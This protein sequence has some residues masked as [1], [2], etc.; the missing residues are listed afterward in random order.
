MQ[1]RS[2]S[3]RLPSLVLTVLVVCIGALLALYWLQRFGVAALG[4]GMAHTP[5]GLSVPI[6]HWAVSSPWRDLIA[7]V[8]LA[9]VLAVVIPWLPRRRWI[10]I[11][12][13]LILTLT[14]L[15]YLLWRGASLNS[16]YPVST[17]LAVLMLLVEVVYLLTFA[18][19]FLPAAWV[20]PQRRRLEADQL[21][22]E[23]ALASGA[24]AALPRVDI[25]ILCNDVPERLVRRAVLTCRNL[26][27]ATS[28]IVLLD[29]A[30][31][32]DL[33]QLALNLGVR[34]GSLADPGFSGAPLI[35][36][37]DAG[38]VP[39]RRFLART[40]GFFD[41]PKVAMVQTGQ[42]YF[43]SEQYNRNLG[44]DLVMSADRDSFFHYLEPARDRFN[45]V[46]GSGSSFVVRLAALSAA[47][48]QGASHLLDNQQSGINLL[49]HGWRVVYL[50]ENLSVGESPATFADYLD[51]RLVS[52]Q[53]HLQVFLQGRAKAMVSKLKPAQLYFF[54]HQFLTLFTP[55]I[56]LIYL[57]LPLLALC[58][59]FSLIQAP[60][61]EFIAYGLPFTL[62]LWSI[63]AWL[64]GGHFSSF[65]NEI[66]EALFAFPAISKIT[67]LLQNPFQKIRHFKDDLSSE[68]YRQSINMLLAWPFLLMLV[69]LLITL[70]FRYLIP[71][72]PGQVA[73]GYGTYLGEDLMLAW[74]LYD[75]LLLLI[76]L[77]C[78]IDQPIRRCGDRLPIHLTARL[79]CEH[80]S[81][82]VVSKDLSESGA[83]VIGPAELPAWSD[84]RGQLEIS[85]HQ[86]TLPVRLVRQQRRDDGM[87]LGLTFDALPNAID[88]QLLDLLYGSGTGEPQPRRTSTVRACL[89]LLS[90]LGRAE[91][92]V[93]TG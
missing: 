51:Q 48:G 16:G 22:Q 23:L 49:T 69:V 50:D 52:M 9:A 63:P 1:T 36:I 62:L 7:P 57:I 37:V 44:I 76:C 20:N 18:L 29:A 19:P 28:T 93:R 15:R 78:C 47:Q 87:F 56:R 68:P 26:V 27:G 12:A 42:S 3:Q 8:G 79:H 35:A 5:Q 14:A 86:L 25:G 54:A 59:G 53:Q 38:M 84:A 90:G 65:W 34:H 11:G 45:A 30:E 39:L 81:F 73:M 71:M 72:I 6:D 17:G 24:G 89:S 70:F 40:I 88:Q 4:D 75:G 92:I 33:K 91:P 64:A 77:L 2:L 41:D 66:Y 61:I 80:G 43:E 32:S 60:L 46:I 67:K 13:Q 82:D 10:Q 58:A 55:F 85:S 31:R 83:A 21:E 74:A